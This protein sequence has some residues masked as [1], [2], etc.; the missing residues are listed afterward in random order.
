M[1]SKKID[2]INLAFLLKEIAELKL[3]AKD[4]EKKINEIYGELSDISEQIEELNSIECFDER[5]NDFLARKK[6]A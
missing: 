6:R 3:A 5:V 1:S 4:T 2:Y